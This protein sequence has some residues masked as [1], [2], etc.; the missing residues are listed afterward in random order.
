MT[1]NYE[2]F[3]DR[4]SRARS[5][6]FPIA[7]PE[8]GVARLSTREEVHAVQDKLFSV[9]F[10]KDE[11]EKDKYYTHLKERDHLVKPLSD[12]Y[13]SQMHSDWIVF[14]DPNN[15]PIGWFMGETEDWETFYL[16]N[17]G[18]IPELLDWPQTGPPVLRKGDHP[19]CS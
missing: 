18:V 15:N 16:R 11:S 14:E 8:G 5:Q 2:S 3:V 1:E 4:V 19:I 10:P 7:L 17:S 9:I 13:F 12:F 6:F